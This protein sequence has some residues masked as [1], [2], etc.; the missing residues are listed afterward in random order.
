MARALLISEK[1]SLMR[2]LQ[3]AYNGMHGLDK[4]DF[5][6]LAGHVVTLNEPGD[7]KE[8]WKIWSL[9]YLPMLLKPEEF[10]YHIIPGDKDKVDAIRKALKENK[11]DYMI[12]ATDPE[13][14]G[15]AIFYSVYQFLKLSLPVKRMWVNDLNESAVQKAWKDL[16]DDQ[17]DPYFRNLTTAALCRQ[18]SDWLVGMNFSRALG[19]PAGRVMSTVELMLADRELAIQN[20][21]P[22]TTYDLQASFSEDYTAIYEPEDSEENGGAFKTKEE[23]EKFQKKLGKTGT[24]KSVEKNRVKENAPLLF[25]LGELQAEANRVYGYTLQETLNI[26]Q[27]LYEAKI[28]TYPRTDCNYIPE[29]DAAR[30][31]AI[32]RDVI[33]RMPGFDKFTRNIDPKR[34]KDYAKSKYVNNAKV[35]AHGA[36]IFTGLA[37]DYD[38]LQQGQKDIV[39]LIAKRI[40]ATMMDPIVTD[41]TKIVTDIDGYKFVS[42]GSIT[43]DKG[44][45]A[46]YERTANE[47]VMP[48]LKEGQKVH[49]ENYE[50]LE[51]V[52]KCPPRY[53]DGTL[54]KAMINIGNTLENKEMA[55]YLKG[56]TPDQGGIGTPATRAAIVEK[57]LKPFS[58]GKN[59]P[60]LIVAERKKKSFF[61]TDDGLKLAEI[62]RPYSF[63]S[64]ILTAEWEKKLS[65]IW[66]G[67]LTQKQYMNQLYEFIQDQVETIKKDKP[68]T[69]RAGG[70]REVKIM[71]DMKCPFCGG[72]IKAT[73][74]YYLC[75]K[76]GKEANACK[77]ILGK[78]TAG[79][80]IT[81]EDLADICAGKETRVLQMHSKKS[82]KDFK[83]S[84]IA[85][86]EKGQV[87]FKFPD[88]GFS[89]A[90]A[91]ETKIKCSCGGSVVLK[92]GKYG[93]YYECTSCKKRMSESWCGHKFTQKEAELIFSGKKTPVIE[94]FKSKSGNT[95]KASMSLKDGKLT[96]NFE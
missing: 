48:D 94:G 67:D 78:D 77:F 1:P 58:R 64:A 40:L 92:D 66:D 15:Q 10:K 19:I 96:P 43:I 20:F 8:E 84:L 32:I 12:D 86:K 37:F 57:I 30:M 83:A 24:V 7:Y 76:Y 26:A 70:A 25:S 38:N 60:P 5:L 39:T 34:I 50:T 22:T 79:A 73:D 31:P 46:L 14:E 45:S 90:P 93:K 23:L 51:R 11:Y 65:E 17:N 54:I 81:E 82:G 72:Q 44:W 71:E 68:A 87:T 62:I 61:V 33:S 3:S 47:L 95:F 56:D 35:K 89:S 55:E 88:S 16:K 74:K 52:T 2:T 21:K 28:T 85:D 49:V 18:Y 36:L 42:H 41:K 13:R 69:Q 63:S 53:N 27:N 29:G 59:R 4:V 91:K 75:E 9:D 80:E 6:S